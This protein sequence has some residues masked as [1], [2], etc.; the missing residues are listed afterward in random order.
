[1]G[2]VSHT[3]IDVPQFTYLKIVACLSGCRPGF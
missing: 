2:F 3:E 1:M